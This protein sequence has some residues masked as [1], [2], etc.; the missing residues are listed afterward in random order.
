M[1][2]PIRNRLGV[3]NGRSCSIVSHDLLILT[4]E[5]LIILLWRAARIGYF[6]QLGLHCLLCAFI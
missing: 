3:L 6:R 2:E 4:C 1:D 5:P